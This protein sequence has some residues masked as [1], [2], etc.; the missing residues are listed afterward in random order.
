[1]WIGRVSHQAGVTY[2][3]VLEVGGPLWPPLDLGDLRYT[4]GHNG[5]AVVHDVVLVR[6]GLLGVV[7][8]RGG[9]VHLSFFAHDDVGLLAMSDVRW[10]VGVSDQRSDED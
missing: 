2:E 8:A 9:V 7:R 4:G 6:L 10:R 5:I 3:I 1:L